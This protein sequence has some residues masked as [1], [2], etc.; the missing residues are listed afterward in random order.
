[1]PADPKMSRRH[2]VVS[3]DGQRFCIADLGSHN[4]SFVDGTQVESSLTSGAA[5]LLRTGESL[6]LLSPD[7]RP[8]VAR[9]LVVRDDLVLGPSMQSIFA[10]AAAGTQLGQALHITGESGSGKEGLARAFHGGSPLGKGPFVAL[11]CATI[12]AG[13]AERLLFGARRGAFSGATADSD[14]IV[15]AADGGTLFL[16][17]LGELDPAVQA[18][19][20]RVLETR[21]VLPMGALKPRRVNLQLCSASHR[22]L[23]TE[24]AEGRFRE[25]LY[26]R[27]MP[28]TRPGPGRDDTAVLT[29]VV[30][31]VRGSAP[32]PLARSARRQRTAGGA[33]P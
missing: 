2:A 28:R 6:F 5:R 23:R 18:K 3:F 22:H 29:R 8:F 14:G 9:G 24:V 16:D 31:G 27:S 26:F 13:I 7:V 25:D 33:R 19:L 10:Q 12:A 11:N 21:E 17:E 15:V 1:M 32:A 20:L 4:G 30:S